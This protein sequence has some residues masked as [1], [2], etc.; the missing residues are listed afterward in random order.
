MFLR[1]DSVGKRGTFLALQG[2]S[3]PASSLHTLQAYSCFQI[4]LSCALAVMDLK[5][6]YSLYPKASHGF[7]GLF[8]SAGSRRVLER[9]HLLGCC[10]PW[11]IICEYVLQTPCS[12]SCQLRLTLPLSLNTFTIHGLQW[13]SPMTS[14]WGN[15]QSFCCS[16]FAVSWPGFLPLLG[17][18]KSPGRERFELCGPQWRNHHHGAPSEKS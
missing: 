9:S 16:P 6:K 18:P 4:Q 14:L 17:L 15:V 7:L 10:F 8:L 5:S 3:F 12:S 13:F 1:G 11:L 2:T